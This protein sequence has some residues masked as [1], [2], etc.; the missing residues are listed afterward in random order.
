MDGEL[1]DIPNANFWLLEHFE[2]ADPIVKAVM[3]VLA[4]ASVWSWGVAIDKWF[5]VSGVKS[6][7]KRFE[8]A[9]WSGQPLD[10]LGDRL[11]S[12]NSSDAMA[13]VFLAGSDEWR[14]ARR[15]AQVSEHHAAAAIDRARA[16]MAVA[17]NR[18]TQRLENGLG[19]LAII[20]SSAPFIGLF[21]TVIG[22]MNAFSDIA[23]QQE[24]N[25]TVVA[26]GI[27]EALLAT[28]VG[29]VAAIP[30]VIAYN[31]LNADSERIL[32]GY[33]SFA[34]E[35]STILSRQLDA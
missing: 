25:L 35:F 19:T 22:I 18:E 3:I 8:N 10:D 32:G 1:G 9:F 15:T 30:A 12:G 26:P 2:N 11:G 14:E 17:A 20:A 13:R 7:A 4:I 23:A 27:A 5:N 16:Q 29:L 33:E 28:A 21:G 6:K 24:T 31:T 34:D